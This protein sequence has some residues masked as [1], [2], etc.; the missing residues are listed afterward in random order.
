[1]I[2]TPADYRSFIFYTAN[3]TPVCSL[4]KKN[5]VQFPEFYFLHSKKNEVEFPEFCFLGE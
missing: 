3:K 4:V 1:M 2:E 5:E